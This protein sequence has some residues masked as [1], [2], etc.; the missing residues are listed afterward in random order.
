MDEEEQE[1]DADSSATPLRQARQLHYYSHA[2]SSVLRKSRS[3]V[4]LWICLK[5]RLQF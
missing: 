2:V 4:S 5:A 1:E 3:S